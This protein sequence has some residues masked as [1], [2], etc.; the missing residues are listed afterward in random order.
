MSQP[1]EDPGQWSPGTPVEPTPATWAT[2]EPAPP[3]DP[4]QAYQQAYQQPFAPQPE[5]PQP[6]Y[7]PPAYQQPA[8]EPPAQEQPAYQQPAYQQPAYQQPAYQPAPT[9]AYPAAPAPRVRVSRSWGPGALAALFI[10][11]SSVLAQYLLTSYWLSGT[12]DAWNWFYAGGAFFALAGLAVVSSS[13]G[14]A[15]LLGFLSGCLGAV[16]TAHAIVKVDPGWKLVV[17]SAVPFMAVPLLLGFIALV[18]QPPRNR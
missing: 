9:P 7:E 14:S 4:Q 13:P 6:A 10:W 3:T 8:Y 18:S 1:P 11:N 17:A 12:K 2:P 16:E 15:R 5:A